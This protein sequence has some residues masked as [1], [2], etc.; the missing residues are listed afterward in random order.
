[1][2]I[3]VFFALDAECS[4]WRAGHRFQSLAGTDGSL[5]ETTFGQ[6]RVRLALIGV[7]ARRLD[8]IVASALDGGIDVVIGA[9]VSGGLQDRQKLG[10]VLV[11]RQVLSERDGRTARADDRLIDVAASCGAR[12]VE[13]FLTSDHIVRDAAR[14][15]ELGARGEAV[16]M[17]SFAIL[18]MAAERGLPGLAV[19][20]V[21]DEVDVELP[22]DF[23]SAIRPD[24]TIR[25]MK[26]FTQAVA[27]PRDWPALVAF[28]QAQRR[29]LDRLAR[30]LDRFVADLSSRASLP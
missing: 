20:V 9:G 25:A 8:S 10:D 6:S 1:M 11:A 14:K 26:L 29:A 28:G 23:E 12:I 17:E 3:A 15:R 27:H 22:L 2:K 4:P 18:A 13:T 21:G 7:G 5:F 16:D 24:G 30:F 19:R